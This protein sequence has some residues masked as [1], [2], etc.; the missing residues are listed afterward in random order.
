M[1]GCHFL[2]FIYLLVN[3]IKTTATNKM[4]SGD[5]TSALQIIITKIKIITT[6]NRT[7]N[8]GVWI[9]YKP[10]FSYLLPLSLLSPPLFMP[11]HFNEAGHI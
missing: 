7:K 11:R 10:Y 5:M 1:L 2:L 3:K 4:V 8:Q 6:G 9:P